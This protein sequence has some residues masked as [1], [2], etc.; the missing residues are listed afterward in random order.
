MYTI[1]HNPKCG[2]SQ[3]ALKILHER[4]GKV[5]IVEYLKTCP[6]KP[7]LVVLIEKLGIRAE[8]LVRKKEPVYVENFAGKQL[9]ESEWIDA[10]V[11][12]PVL[13]DRPIIVKD[14]RAVIGRG[15]AELESILS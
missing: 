3:D 1:Y 12:Y 14:G 15:Q 8:E 5:R 2:A 9:T 10:L 6:T 7:E 11:K 4:A 13:I